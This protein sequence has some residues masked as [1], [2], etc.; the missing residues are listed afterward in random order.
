MDATDTLSSSFTRD[1]GFSSAMYDVS[2][3]VV[4]G[5]DR[6]QVKLYYQTTSREYVEFLGDEINGTGGTLS[7]PTPSGEAEAYIFTGTGFIPAPGAESC[8]FDDT[9]DNLRCVSYPPCAP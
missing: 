5:V 8:G 9:E 4:G 2:L 1:Y 3:T 6:I 7:S